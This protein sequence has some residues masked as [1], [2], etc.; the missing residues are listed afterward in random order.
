MVAEGAH[1]ALPDSLADT[2]EHSRTARERN[3]CDTDSKHFVLHTFRW[4]S[5]P[6][7]SRPSASREITYLLLS[8]RVVSGRQSSILKSSP[9]AMRSAP[10][11]S[12]PWPRSLP[13]RERR[14]STC[15][16]TPLSLPSSL[17]LYVMHL[18]KSCLDQALR[19]SHNE[20][21]RGHDACFW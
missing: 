4:M 14:P 15:C 1:N 7:E 17:R 19:V 21:R 13:G 3:E 9:R 18:T 16:R 6:Q 12:T 11:W 10:A 8:T 2:T 5:R 20:T